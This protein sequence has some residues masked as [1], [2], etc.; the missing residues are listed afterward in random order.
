MEKEIKQLLGNLIDN[1]NE[2]N[3]ATIGDVSGHAS[4]AKSGKGVFVSENKQGLSELS[5]DSASLQDVSFQ[6][7]SVS[8]EGFLTI[9][10]AEP[11][12]DNLAYAI[13]EIKT[14]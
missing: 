8:S 4:V 7:N 14:T 2:K 10:K 6:I 11:T 13:F 3:A 1:R 9:Q 12:R 5:K